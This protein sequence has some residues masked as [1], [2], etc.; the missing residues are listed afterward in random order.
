VSVRP[1]RAADRA[2]DG[3]QPRSASCARLTAP[4]FDREGVDLA[5]RLTRVLLLGAAFLT[6]MN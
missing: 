6:A 1:C 4:G 5:V 3:R 2:A